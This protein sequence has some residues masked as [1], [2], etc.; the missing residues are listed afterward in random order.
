MKGSP[1]EKW[2]GRWVH[3]GCTEELI[4]PTQAEQ[5]PPRPAT[6]EPR[7]AEK[8]WKTRIVQ[9]VQ[10]ELAKL[11]TSTGGRSVDVAAVDARI[12]A[13]VDPTKRWV[14]MVVNSLTQ[15]VA[16]R[17]RDDSAKIEALTTQA[18]KLAAQIADLEKT[19]RVE[20][21]FK[22]PKGAAVKLDENVHPVFEEVMFHAIDCRENVVLVGPTGCGKTHLAMQV[23]KGRKQ[24]FNMIS[25]SI[26]VT[27]S[28][29]FGS[30]EP[31]DKGGFRYVMS[32]FATA[33]REGGVFLWDE[34]DALD[35]NVFLSVN[36]PLSNGELHPPKAFGMQPIKKHDDFI[37][38]LAANTYGNGADREYVGRNQLDAAS[39]NR[40]TVIEMDYDDAVEYKLATSVAGS[41][42]GG[43]LAERL[44]G[45]RRRL[46]DAK[47]RRHI[48]TRD[49]SRCATWLAYGKDFEY[50]DRKLFQSWTPS[51][52]AKI[53]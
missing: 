12:D 44:H 21:T 42:L 53:K 2:S 14:E 7:G 22:Q 31:N 13:K 10:T 40:L 39:L 28:S 18:E 23:A 24:S 43:K 34:V 25:C 51:E 8:A 33:Y 17:I 41:E 1:I 32:P 3:D 50:V 27:E 11:G 6:D 4:Q 29:I 15:E 19:R 38:L 37:C 20:I 49:F 16:A 9:V 52:I 47:L 46:R 36:A 45:Y 30:R 26:G 48:T 5:L 35:P